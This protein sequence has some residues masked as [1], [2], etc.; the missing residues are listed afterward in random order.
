MLK[1]HFAENKVTPKRDLEYFPPVKSRLVDNIMSFV[2]SLPDGDTEGEI[3]AES[4]GG[5][6]DD[7]NEARVE[8]EDI[9][10]DGSNVWPATLCHYP[11][12][13]SDNFIRSLSLCGLKRLGDIADAVNSTIV[14]M[15]IS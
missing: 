5:V 12:P 9:V 7:P 11:N 4:E 13:P 14:G 8:D 2:D 6:D 15:Y 10:S 3:V 1:Q